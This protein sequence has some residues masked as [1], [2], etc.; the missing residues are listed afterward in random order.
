MKLRVLEG[1]F[2]ESCSCCCCFVYLL[3]E[4]RGLEGGKEQEEG[5]REMDKRQLCLCALMCRES[6]GVEKDG[7]TN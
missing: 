1:P 2:S 6:G 5:R 7:E 4:A 3:I